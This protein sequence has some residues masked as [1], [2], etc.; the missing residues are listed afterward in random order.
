M[1]VEHYH[2]SH[3]DIEDFLPR[4]LTIGHDMLKLDD[5]RLISSIGSAA[6]SVL[7]FDLDNQTIVE[8]W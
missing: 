8:S 3:F 6:V 7:S 4:N 2:L 5:L 1:V